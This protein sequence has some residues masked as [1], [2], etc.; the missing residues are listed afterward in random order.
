MKASTLGKERETPLSIFQK[1]DTL[2]IYLALFVLVGLFAMSNKAFLTPSNFINVVRQISTLGIMAVGM[3]MILITGGVDLSVGAQLSIVGVSIGYMMVNLHIN[4]FLATALGIS[5]CLVIGLVNGIIVTRTKIPPL[6][7]TMGMLQIV[8]G[9]SFTISSG[10]PIFGFPKGYNTLGQGLIGVIPIPIIFFVVALI[11]GSFILNKTVFGRNLY[12]IGSNAE[13]SR[14]SGINVKR[15]TLLAYVL[16]AGFFG[17]AGVLTLSR[18]NS[19]LPITGIGQ[20]LDVLTA[21]VLGGV[22]FTGGDGKIS[23]VIAGVLI[24][25]VLSNGMVMAGLDEYLQV[26]LK[27]VVLLFALSLDFLKQRKA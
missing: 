14:L 8:K 6:I 15:N 2:G 1:Y 19:A 16:G 21:I 13:A 24:L 17:V 25:G 20:E 27:G 7:A 12:A 23:G 10:L 11:I 26:I 4:P 9:L 3:T 22:S 18:V 5:L